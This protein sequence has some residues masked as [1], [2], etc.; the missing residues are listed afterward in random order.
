MQKKAVAHRLGSD[1]EVGEKNRLVRGQ[2]QLWTRSTPVSCKRKAEI[3]VRPGDRLR[4]TLM[5]QPLHWIAQFQVPERIARWLVLSA[6][7][8]WDCSR[9]R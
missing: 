9:S 8:P 3:A 5:A 4:H 2:M 6:Y 7:G 1:P